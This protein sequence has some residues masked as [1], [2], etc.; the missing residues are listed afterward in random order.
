MFSSRVTEV[1]SETGTELSGTPGPEAPPLP[2]GSPTQTTFSGFSYKWPVLDHATDF[3]KIFQSFINPKQVAYGLFML[4]TSSKAPLSPAV[5]A[6]NLSLQLDLSKAPPNED[7][8]EII[9]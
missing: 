6:D 3:L 1:C 9:L 5:E 7:H 2:S 4:R 8:L